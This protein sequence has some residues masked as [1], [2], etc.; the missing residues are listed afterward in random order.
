MCVIQQRVSDVQQAKQISS[1]FRLASSFIEVASMWSQSGCYLQ[2]GNIQKFSE[3][4]R[5]IG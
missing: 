4:Q 1:Q 2:N 5:G 3:Q